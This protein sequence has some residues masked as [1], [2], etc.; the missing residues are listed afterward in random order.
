MAFPER[1]GIP[2]S[3]ADVTPRQLRVP[4]GD[5]T[6]HAN[7]AEALL[8]LVLADP[9]PGRVVQ[10][11]EGVGGVSR[12]GFTVQV[13]KC[14]VTIEEAPTARIVSAT[15]GCGANRPVVLN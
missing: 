9:E 8:A 1:A 5:A 2:F 10:W 12:N 4:G 7:G 14:A 11:M 13:G 3:I 15:I 6:D